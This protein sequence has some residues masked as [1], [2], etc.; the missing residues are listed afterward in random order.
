MEISEFI[1]KKEGLEIEILKS[2]SDLVAEF[3]NDTGYSPSGINIS[4]RTETS[5][6][7]EHYCFERK[8]TNVKCYFD[9]L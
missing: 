4:I 5:I 9:L 8:L 3:H 1:A 2:I 7:E 6:G